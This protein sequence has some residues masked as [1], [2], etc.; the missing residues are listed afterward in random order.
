MCGIAGFYQLKHNVFKDY[1]YKLL[2]GKLKNMRDS[3]KHRGPNDDEIFM[4][5]F[6]GLAHTRLSIRDIKGGA[7][8]MTRK[9]NGKRATIAYNGEIY[10]TDQL[11]NKLATY[12]IDLRTTSD[13]EIILYC[14]LVFGPKIFKELNGIFAF[15][16]YENNK[17]TIVRDHVGVKPLFYYFDGSQFVFS[18]EIKG[19]FAY[20]ITPRLNKSS[21]CEIIGL[22]PAHTPGNGVFENIHEVLS[23]HY[24]TINLTPDKKIILED[25]CYWKLRSKIHKDD[26]NATVMH[27][28]FLIEDS[29]K[30]QMVSDIPICTFLS[31]GL[32]SS[33]VSS[34]V[35]KHLGK[36]S[37]ATYSFD[38]VDNN[39]NFKANSFQTTR[40][41][42]YVDIM[43]DYLHSK[44]HYLECNNKNQ[45]ECLFKAVDARDMPCMADVESSMLY[46][47]NLVSRECKVTLTGECADEIFGGYPWFHRKEMLE[48]NSFPWSYDLSARTFL[49]KDDF[50]NELNIDEYV[51]T[52]YQNSVNECEFLEEENETETLRR[53]VTWLNIKWFMMTLLNRMDRCGMYSGLEARVPFADY[54]ILEYVFNVPWEYKCYKNQPKSLLVECG[55]KYLPN[56]ILYRKKTPYPK[57]YDP[58]YEKLLGQMVMEEF[59]SNS[60]LRDIIDKEKLSSF[61]KSPKDYG[62]PWYGQLMAGPQMLA[63]VLQI[64]YWLRKYSMQ[65]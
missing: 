19:I 63:Y 55:K 23:G 34:I 35:S 13:T 39:I 65:P 57:T 14:Y 10:N 25:Y 5:G 28:N 11:K 9:Y 61:I 12:D 40:D 52:A 38:F 46:F 7:Q 56:E 26:Y 49:F 20:G 51:A 2:T 29:I 41:R 33:L 64:G 58:N 54:R 8:P 1:S 53:K 60:A 6:C 21:W 45:I 4:E 30:N 31:G 32:D 43:K 62:K 27:T 36:K 37:L 42:P 44:H 18:S 22:G 59:D 3:I 48:Q 50:I 47:C 17:L 16:I 15:A 24:L